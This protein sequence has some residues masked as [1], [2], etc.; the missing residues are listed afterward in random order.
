MC[1]IVFRLGYEDPIPPQ[2]PLIIKDFVFVFPV[3]PPP[4]QSYSN[5]YQKNSLPII[6]SRSEGLSSFGNNLAPSSPICTFFPLPDSARKP[7]N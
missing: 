4:E 6:P 5:F 2:A 3:V 7:L 1:P